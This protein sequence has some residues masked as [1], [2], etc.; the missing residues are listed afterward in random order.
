[1]K[2]KVVILLLLGI[3][4]GLDNISFNDGTTSVTINEIDATTLL[5]SITIGEVSFRQINH[6]N[7]I[8]TR[9]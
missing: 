7:E 9:I 2:I 6:N 3:S 8:F 1:M 5:F 4:F